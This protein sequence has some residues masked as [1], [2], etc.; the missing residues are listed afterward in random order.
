MTRKWN[1][2]AIPDSIVIPTGAVIFD[3]ESIEEAHAK[4]SGKLM[5]K[6]QFRVAEGDP[7]TANLV[8]FENFVLGTDDD[9]MMQDPATVGPGARNLKN[10]LKAAGM[11][12][13]NEDLDEVLSAAIGKQV[14]AVVEMFL[15]DGKRNPQYA[16]Q[17][18]N[19]VSRWFQP[20]EREVGS[21][22]GPR[23]AAKP[24]AKASAPTPAPKPPKAAAPK[25]R[26]AP[27]P[28]EDEEPG[29]VPPARPAKAP[30]QAQAPPVARVKCSLCNQLIPRAEFAAHV[31]ECTGGE[32][33]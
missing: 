18:R 12:V 1:P 30:V 33:E 32:D 8:Y 23:P 10:M 4:D 27:P 5:F 2:D 16:G 28:D 15:D 14:G 31:A 24:V 6:T 3:I 22:N 25:A 17:P 19:R 11:D 20:G 26:P 7:G 29:E 13:S 21:A 9:P